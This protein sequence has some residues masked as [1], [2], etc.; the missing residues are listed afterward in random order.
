MAGALAQQLA[1]GQT[2]EELEKLDKKACP[3]AASPS[4][5][6]R[7][8]GRLGCPHDYIF[9]EKELD[10]LIANI[11]AR[12]RTPASGR[13]AIPAAPSTRPT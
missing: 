7:N 4:T 3:C 5:S 6:F 10:P 8:Q 13:S 2:A 9:F 11:P 12:P 1:V